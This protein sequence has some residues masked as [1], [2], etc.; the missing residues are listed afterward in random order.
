MTLDDDGCLW[1]AVHGSGNVR[2][3]TPE[4]ALDRVIR[5]PVSMVTSCA[6]GAPE[7]LDL[8]ITTM[9]YGMSAEAKRDQPLAG[10]LFHRRPGVRAANRFGTPTA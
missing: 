4:G 2:R 6:F 3:Y 8:F 9:Q 10:A 5:V 1:V 7:F